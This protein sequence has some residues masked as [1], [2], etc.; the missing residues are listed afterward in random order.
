MFNIQSWF[1][2]AMQTPM[3][4]RI[5]IS[6]ISFFNQAGA[7]QGGQFGRYTNWLKPVTWVPP[8]IGVSPSV[9][10]AVSNVTT[11]NPQDYEA[12]EAAVAWNG[13]HAMTSISTLLPIAVNSLMILKAGTKFINNVFL[14]WTGAVTSTDVLFS[15]KD[16]SYTSGDFTNAASGTVPA[17]SF[18]ATVFGGTGKQLSMSLL[19]TGRFSVALRIVDNAGNY[20]LFPME[21]IVLP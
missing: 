9:L 18:G 4:P 14:D 17:Y 3:D 21:W 6:S 8:V 19:T 15:F 20:S 12:I 1:D 2:L 16:N 10:P 11:A 13:S 7:Q 5:L